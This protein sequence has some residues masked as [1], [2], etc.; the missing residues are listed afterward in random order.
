MKNI[1]ISLLAVCAFFPVL[2]SAQEPYQ[3]GKH[4]QVLA[5]PVRTADADKIEVNEVF[6]Y[7]CSHCFQFESAIEPWA[8]AQPADVLFNRTPAIWQSAMEVHARAYYAA[9]Q[10]NVL[11]KMHTVI[12]RTMHTEKHPLDNEDQLASLFVANGVDEA[13][14]R[15]SYNSF[16]VQSQARQADARVRAYGVEGTPEII[17]NGKYR[18]SG[19]DNGGQAGML[20][21][22]SYLIGVERQARGT[23]KAK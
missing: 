17:V 15:K 23:S 19:R 3:A 5:T 9:L 14:F 20:D 12:F 21:V 7:G 6:W 16:S 8:K 2:I 18:I 11:D 10:L 13:A 4:Y 1:L 22:A